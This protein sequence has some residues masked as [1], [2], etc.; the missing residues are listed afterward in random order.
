MSVPYKIKAK[1]CSRLKEAK[2]TGHGLRLDS[3]LGLSGRGGGML[4]G[5]PGGHR[6]LCQCTIYSDC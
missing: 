4:I 5:H 1:N 6:L 3:V 2:D